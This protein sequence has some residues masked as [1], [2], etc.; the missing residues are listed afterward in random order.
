MCAPGALNHTSCFLSTIG[1]ENNVVVTAAEKRK[2]LCRSGA[3]KNFRCGWIF[4]RRPILLHLSGFPCQYRRRVVGTKFTT[5]NIHLYPTLIIADLF[6][7][8]KYFFVI[9]NSSPFLFSHF[10]ECNNR[11]FVILRLRACFYS[12]NQSGFTFLI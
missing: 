12:H 4:G 5:S 2:P 11:I 10:L 7:F 6:T 9:D 8:V 3:V 1:R